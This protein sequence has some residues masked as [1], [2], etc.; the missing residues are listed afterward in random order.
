[1]LT[2]S[3]FDEN[4]DEND[5]ASFDSDMKLKEGTLSTEG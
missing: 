3:E 5:F 1:V 2:G 4:E